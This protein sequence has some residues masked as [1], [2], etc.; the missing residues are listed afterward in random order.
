[1]TDQSP[2]SPNQIESTT[3]ILTKQQ[4]SLKKYAEADGRARDGVNIIGSLLEVLASPFY[5]PTETEVE[6]PFVGDPED[7]QTDVASEGAATDSE[8]DRSE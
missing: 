5:L 8:G 7:V 6:T 3:T 2:L 1:M 4:E